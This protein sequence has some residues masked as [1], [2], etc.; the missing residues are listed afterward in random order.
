VD[1]ARGT[2]EDTGSVHYYLYDTAWE[3]SVD[4][5]IMLYGPLGTI[6]RGYEGLYLYHIM[7]YRYCVV[8]EDV[9]NRSETVQL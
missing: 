1:R 7:V 3:L 5:G 2:N 8:S 4:E 9:L 6:R